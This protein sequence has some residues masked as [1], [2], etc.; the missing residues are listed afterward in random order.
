MI[1][2]LIHYLFYFQIFYV[3][4]LKSY[5]IINYIF[6]VVVTRIEDVLTRYINLPDQERDKYVLNK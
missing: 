2:A 1:V 3:L 6:T 4:K 5:A